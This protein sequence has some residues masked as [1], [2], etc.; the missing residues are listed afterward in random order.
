[1][2]TKKIARR[3]NRKNC[4]I[5]IVASHFTNFNSMFDNSAKAENNA[6]NLAKTKCRETGISNINASR[7]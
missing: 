7:N 4:L 6:V 5:S 3:L 1:M 2:N